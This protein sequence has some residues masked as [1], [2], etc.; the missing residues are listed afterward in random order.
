VLISS[1]QVSSTAA[2]PAGRRPRRFV[3]VR[4][5]LAA[6]AAAILAVVGLQA[7]RAAP[8]YAL[9]AGRVCVFYYLNSESGYIGHTAWAFS[10]PGSTV[11]DYGSADGNTGS[12]GTSGSF[13]V[14]P[15]RAG[16]WVLSAT[17]GFE[18]VVETF[19]ARSY[20]Y[21]TCKNTPVSAV[22]AA[23]S[24]ALSDRTWGLLSN[25]CAQHVSDILSA[26]YD[27]TFST[28]YGA[29]VG[30][31]MPVDWFNTLYT[32]Q[33]F[34][35]PQLLGTPDHWKGGTVRTSGLAMREAGRTGPASL[36]QTIWRRIA[37]GTQV[38]IVCWMNG[39]SIT[40]TWYDGETYSTA[41]WDA[42]IYDNATSWTSNLPRYAI[43]DAYVDTGGATE[44]MV[45]K[46][47]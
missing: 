43:S 23:Q 16:V 1:K 12:M 26:Y 31:V 3:A 24:L 5:V 32:S 8:A 36:S 37:L 33:G 2:A 22:G 39:P 15:H 7:V 21:Y 44:T 18:D 20:S 14:E 4:R 47:T 6:V 25:N 35:T 42:V 11:W 28:A 19:R 10:V 17:Y 9:G 30:T 46:C 29:T 27:H 34:E 38:V 45:P 13:D 40:G 41:V